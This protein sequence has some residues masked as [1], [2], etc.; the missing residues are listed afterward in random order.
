MGLLSETFHPTL[1]SWIK[2]N[3]SET[4]NFLCE[5]DAVK[6]TTPAPVQTTTA[7]KPL[8]CPYGNN[9]KRHGEYCYWETTYETERLNWFQARTYCQAFGGD[10]ASYQ[11]EKEED[12]GVGGA[13]AHF[14]GLWIGIQRGKEDDIFRW[15]DGTQMNYTN[16]EINEPNLKSRSKFCVMHGSDDSQWKLDYCGVRRWF[17]CKA[18]LVRS[19]LMPDLP[20]FTKIKC[21]FTTT[22]AFHNWYLYQDN[23]Y[24]VVE[25]KRYSWD[26]AQTFCQD[27]GAHLASVH[28][29]EETDF[30]LTVTSVYPETDF[31]IG[32]NSRG[33]HS[34]FTWSDE[35]PVDF[36]YWADSFVANTTER[37]DNCVIFNKR[38]GSWT[39]DHCNRL[40]GVVCKRGINDNLEFTSPP[41]TPALPGN[42]QSVWYSLGN[43]CYKVFGRLWSQRIKWN[44]AKTECEK[45]GAVLASI[46]SNEEQDFLSDLIM[47]TGTSVWIG[48]QTLE[49]GTLFQW[50]DDTRIDYTNWNA[51]EPQFSGDPDDELEGLFEVENSCVEVL[52]EVE[53]MGKWNSCGCYRK[54]A[55][56]CQKSKDPR[57][58]QP[59]E[60]PFACETVK[61]WSRLGSSC[62]KV[63]NKNSTWIEAQSE[64]RTYEA[65]LVSF[66]ITT[67]GL[68]LRRRYTFDD[69]YY[70]TGMR[71]MKEDT[72]VMVTGQRLVNSNWIPGQPQKASIPMDNCVVIN[73]NN[74][75][76]VRSCQEQ[77][78]FI[79]EWNIDLDKEVTP[80]KKHECTNSSGGWEDIGGSSCYLFKEN[81]RLTWNEA[82]AYCFRHGG[83][84][85]SFHSIDDVKLVQEYLT[86]NVQSRF[87]HIGLG[88]RKDGSYAWVDN[89]PFDF[90]N[91]GIGEPDHSDRNCVEMTVID[92]KWNDI[93]CDEMRRGFICSISKET[94]S[95][96]EPMAVNATKQEEIIS[97]KLTAG[98]IFGIVICILVILAVVGV[99]IYYL[100]PSKKMKPYLLETEASF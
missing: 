53:A 49:H 1:Y 78:P 91:W 42:C 23:C 37:V 67:V 47:E 58:T 97:K 77:H 24:L 84:L 62:Y 89:S 25:K 22:S 9:W 29:F 34:S 30:L 44:E 70:W 80:T 13:R 93:D 10:L 8:G 41:T 94:G 83:H 21:N 87:L 66:R 36:L 64:C 99:T 28:S 92:G 52:H 100:Y 73:N 88:R 19:S 12:T 2:S 60:D 48:L 86:R 43:K 63:F 45:H 82:M 46:H 5:M 61:G 59:S 85:T 14:R 81:E 7:L 90:T 96:L 3:C 74:R 27:N 20:S 55:Y 69:G 18:P 33:L 56:V 32:L 71:E 6:V 26:T 98:G 40:Y 17:V 68:F 16:W 51:D 4:H 75:W 54:N 15:V 50:T 79:C 39:S 95:F 38:E 76:L 65:N 31:W 35:T 72:Y 11:T 57:I